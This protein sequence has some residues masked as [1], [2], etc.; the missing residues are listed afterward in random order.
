MGKQ[1]SGKSE[2]AKVG[3]ALGIPVVTMGDVVRDEARKQ[4]IP[5]TSEDVGRFADELRRKYG[6]DIIARLCIPIIRDISSSVIIDGIR[7]MAEVERF[8]KEFGEDFILIGID[9]DE[10]LRYERAKKRNR[11]DEIRSFEEFLKREEREKK[12]GVEEAL[13][14]ANIIIENNRTLEEFRNKIREVLEKWM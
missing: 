10:K 11:A 13:N 6:E 1:C 2:A 7:S 14:N 12:W 5:M 3:R 9:A 4:K 8:K